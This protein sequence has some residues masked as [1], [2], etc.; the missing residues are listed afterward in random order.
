MKKFVN[1]EELQSL[2]KKFKEEG[3][4]IQLYHNELY[5]YY[6]VSNDSKYVK[7]GSHI[8]TNIGSPEYNIFNE[9]CKAFEEMNF[10][11][12]EDLTRDE[13]KEKI[14]N[15]TKQLIADSNAKL[16]KINSKYYIKNFFNERYYK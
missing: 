5:L 8:T 11:W 2:L 12:T 13:L 16:K 14:K 7:T 4:N 6:S 15:D 10:I 3:L 1:N 9:A